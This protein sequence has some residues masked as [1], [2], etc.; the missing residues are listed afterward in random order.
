MCLQNEIHS[1]LH[2]AQGCRNVTS[3]GFRIYT[4]FLLPYH[5]KFTSHLLSPTLIRPVL[6]GMLFKSLQL[7]V[8][9]CFGLYFPTCFSFH[10]SRFNL[11]LQS[12]LLFLILPVPSVLFPCHFF[13]PPY[14]VSSANLT[15]S[16]T[17]FPIH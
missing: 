8:Y 11:I 4:D 2:K 5:K 12:P 3:L 16:V 9:L 1:A 14:L 7:L 15:H 13:T 6:P 10:F 17:P